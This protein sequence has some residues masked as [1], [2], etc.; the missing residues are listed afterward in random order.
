MKIQNKGKQHCLCKV[1]LLYL[2]CA[3]FPV[4]TAFT[5][6][7]PRMVIV[8]PKVREPYLSV[9]E[10]IASGA[11]KGFNGSSVRVAI[12]EGQS[13]RRLLAQYDNSIVLA[14]GS[15]ASN[16]LVG[17]SF[18]Y[19][20]V[21]GAVGKRVQN[22]FGLTMLPDPKVIAEKVPLLSPWVKE[23]HV[24]RKKNGNYI[25]LT[26]AHEFLIEKSISLIIHEAV[27][28]RS[29]AAIYR[30]LAKTLGESQAL[31]IL[32]DGSYANN[33][34]LAMILE[35]AWKK[36]FVVFSSSPIHVKRGALFSVYPNNF[37]MGAS[38]GRIVSDV[39]DGILKDPHMESLQDVFVA[40]NERTSNHL[41][42]MITD[43]MKEHIDLVLPAR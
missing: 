26:Q 38:L 43:D 20:L 37:E 12:E 25:D 6:A 33:A 34:I 13:A 39:A 40:V 11:E 24:I 29:A 16:E 14:L 5:F 19:P 31:W 10:D 35:A 22:S 2:F 7:Q 17:E 1:M 28:I 21:S 23:V 9:F 4:S 30:Q 36:N 32:P 8:Y 18:S 27:D 15:R 3:V 41:G 42:I